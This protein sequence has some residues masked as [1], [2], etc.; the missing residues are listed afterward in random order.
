MSSKLESDIVEMLNE[1]GWNLV[2]DKKK[3]LYVTSFEGENGIYQLYL[4]VM[5]LDNQLLITY[6]YIPIKSPKDKIAEVAF[7][8][9]KINREL[10]F[11]NF[12]MDYTNGEIAFRN[13]MHFLGEEFTKYMAA[14]TI[15]SCAFT[16][17]KYF[18]AIKFLIDTKIS[19]EDALKQVKC[20][21]SLP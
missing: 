2:P 18:P 20:D 19:P 9:N 11:G 13:G 15:S 14:N 17:D 10:Y 21:R 1:D 6:S 3:G 12:E 4:N 7:L 16:V 8:L 5:N